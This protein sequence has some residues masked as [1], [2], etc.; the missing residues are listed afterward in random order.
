MQTKEKFISQGRKTQKLSLLPYNVEELDPMQMAVERLRKEN[1]TDPKYGEFSTVRDQIIKGLL[2]GTKTVINPKIKDLESVPDFDFQMKS[3]PVWNADNVYTIFVDPADSNRIC[4]FLGINANIQK[5]VS[6]PGPWSPI[7]LGKITSEMYDALKQ[8]V[9]TTEAIAFWNNDRLEYR[10]IML[11]LDLGT[12]TFNTKKRALTSVDNIVRFR[13]VV[14]DENGNIV[15]ECNQIIYKIM[16]ERKSGRSTG[17]AFIGHPGRSKLT[18]PANEDVAVQLLNEGRH[19][20]R[21]KAFV[22]GVKKRWLTC[23]PEGLKLDDD[24]LL[25]LQ[26]SINKLPVPRQ[27]QIR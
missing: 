24:E 4:G 19:V 9:N 27:M 26:Q 10:R 16:K 3:K 18:L 8:I 7:P 5:W 15:E 1:P 11:S 17:A 23:F 13:G 21:A 14:H 20:I 6:L 22:P 12:T 25:K 2:E